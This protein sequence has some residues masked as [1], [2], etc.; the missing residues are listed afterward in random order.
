MLASSRHRELIRI[1]WQRD[2]IEAL[3]GAVP[4]RGAFPY[5][6]GP[7]GERPTDSPDRTVE[8]S[9]PKR[10]TSQARKPVL[11]FS[12]PS[13]PQRYPRRCPKEPTPNRSERG[14]PDSR[15]HFRKDYRAQERI[16]RSWL[17]QRPSQ[18]RPAQ[19]IRL[20]P[21]FLLPRFPE[22]CQPAARPLSPAPSYR[23]ALSPRTPGSA[24]LRFV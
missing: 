21:S 10:V 4:C 9:P 5:R 23:A 22:F 13:L 8:A 3:P 16:G 19:P 2:S 1:S 6:A 7:L 11:S 18:L 12:P 20:H 15:Q 14:A 24:R 17:W